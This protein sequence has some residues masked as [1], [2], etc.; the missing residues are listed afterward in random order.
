M[1]ARLSS[2]LACALL[3]AS[4]AMP[5]LARGKG[6]KASSVTVTGCL[7]QGNTASEYSIQGDDGKTYM[8]HSSAV[9]LKDHIGHKVTV[10][11]SMS[12]EKTTKAEAKTGTM[13]EENLNVRNLQM[14][15]T[16]CSK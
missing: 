4:L 16:S 14:V 7:A 8:L 6:N 10:T 12:R 9:N 11:G 15:S 13:P 1:I 2:F 5:G 3:A